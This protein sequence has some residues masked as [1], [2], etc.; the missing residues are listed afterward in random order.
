MLCVNLTDLGASNHEKDRDTGTTGLTTSIA[1][2]GAAVTLGNGSDDWLI[3]VTAQIDNTSGAGNPF[4]LYLRDG[5][6]DTLLTQQ[7]FEASASIYVVS[8]MVLEEA[9]AAS[10]TFTVGGQMVAGT[11]D[12]TFASIVAIRLNGFAEFEKATSAGPF[13]AGSGADVDLL[14]LSFTTSASTSDWAFLATLQDFWQSSGFSGGTEIVAD[15]NS[16][17]DVLVCSDKTFF[18]ETNDQAN[19][20]VGRILIPTIV[21]NIG[22][23][24]TVDADFVMDPAPSFASQVVRDMAFVAFPWRLADTN[25]E[26]YVVGNSGFKTKIQG[27][28]IQIN[29]AYTI[30]VADGTD[31]QV[32][33]TDGDGT[34]S[35]ATIGGSGLGGLPDVDL[36]GAADNDLL[37]RSGGVWIDTA[38]I[39]T[40]DGAHLVLPLNNDAAT[41]T[42]AFGDGNSG[43]YEQSDNIIGVAIAGVQTF[44]FS[45]S[46]FSSALGTGPAMLNE[47]ASATNPT[48]IPDRGDVDTGIGQATVDQ[49]SLIAG[50]VEIL[51][52]TESTEEKLTAFFPIFIAEQAAANVDVGGQGQLWVRDDSP[53]V[54]VFTNDVGTDFDLGGGITVT[55]G[56][57]TPTW[58]GFS[59]DPTAT[60]RWTKYSPSI[61]GGNSLV[62]LRVDTGSGTGTSDAT[63]FTLASLPADITP[64]SFGTGL[65]P[66]AQM[67]DNGTVNQYGAFSINTSNVMTFFLSDPA[68]IAGFTASGSKGFSNNSIFTYG[69]V[70]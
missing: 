10:T 62:I 61:A 15:I 5:S 58:T 6:T 57:F 20:L 32:L 23:G 59:T 63:G 48:L 7:D 30:P 3:F 13:T 29:G 42:L 44:N 66:V 11:A 19:D 45:G 49:L 12:I 26:T 21:T 39:L 54:L 41:P 22:S 64:A 34:L 40:W 16:A 50:G 36:T 8:G 38:G 69:L 53:N 43:F 37:Y 1:S 33:Q 14:T 31:G 25:P 68:A 2:T 67:V 46:T 47:A 9:P 18:H 70:E 60:M 28:V 51:R 55:T 35:F 52:L 17:G 27:S 24:L 65:L 56:T 4:Q